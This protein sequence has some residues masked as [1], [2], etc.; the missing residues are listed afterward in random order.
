LV[1]NSITKI[2]N[3]TNLLNKTFKIKNFGD[4]TYFLGLEIARNKTRIHLGQR[5]YFRSS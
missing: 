2:E 4:L 3:L 1:G 5:K